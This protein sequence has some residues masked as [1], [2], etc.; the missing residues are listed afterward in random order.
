MGRPH[1]RLKSTPGVV[2]APFR[3]SGAQSKEPDSTT[4][5]GADI[6]FSRAFAFKRSR[7]LPSVSRTRSTE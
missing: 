2:R 7:T 3:K 6:V 4:E 1:R 5:D